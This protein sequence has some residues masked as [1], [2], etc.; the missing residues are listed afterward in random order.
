MNVD[1]D[2]KWLLSKAFEEGWNAAMESNL[3]YDDKT[4]Y[5]Y[6]NTSGDYKYSI[7]DRTNPYKDLA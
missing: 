7:G 4:D 2:L 3:S 6:Y 5:S 1:V